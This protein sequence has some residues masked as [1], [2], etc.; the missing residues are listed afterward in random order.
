MVDSLYA[1]CNTIVNFVYSDITR[2]SVRGSSK[3]RP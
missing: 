1:F 2:P 3:V